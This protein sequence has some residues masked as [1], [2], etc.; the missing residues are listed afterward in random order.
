L[1]CVFVMNS[2][3]ECFAKKK[4]L[5]KAEIQQYSDDLDGLTK[6]VYAHS[7]FSPADNQK[8]INMKLGLDNAI[9]SGVKPEFA[10]LFYKMG[11]LLESREYKD[12]ATDCFQTIL[13]N[14]ADTPLAP[15][16]VRE[17]TKM[18]VKIQAPTMT[19]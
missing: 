5:S 15:R 9:L 16:A 6:K 18:G 13:E 10:P 1:V 19:K 3:N 17:L 2:N 11:V 14:F 8:M 7:L 12:E 4:G